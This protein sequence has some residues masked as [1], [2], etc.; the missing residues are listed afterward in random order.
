VPGSQYYF[1]FLFTFPLRSGEKFAGHVWPTILTESSQFMPMPDHVL[2]KAFSLPASYRQ[3]AHTA[4]Y[5]VED[6]FRLK[7]ARLSEAYTKRQITRSQLAMARKALLQEAAAILA[8][9][10]GDNPT[11]ILTTLRRQATRQ[12]K[13]SRKFSAADYLNKIASFIV[14]AQLIPLPFTLWATSS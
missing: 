2:S 12:N 4:L 7:I 5:R 8:P 9:S 13:D 11:Q 3:A 10:P 14:I 6:A 1:L